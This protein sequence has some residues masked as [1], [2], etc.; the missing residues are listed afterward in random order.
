MK[1]LNEQIKE[2]KTQLINCKDP[3]QSEK[4]VNE[5]LGLHKRSLHT[6]T[7]LEV[8]C[9]EVQETVDFGACKISRTIRGFLFEAKGGMYTFVEHRMAS[10]CAMLNTIFAL[11]KEENKTKK[12]SKIYDTFV[13]AVEYVMQAPIFASLNEESLFSVATSVLHNFNEYS[14]RY[15]T[16]AQAPEHTEED[17]KEGQSRSMPLTYLHRTASLSPC[18]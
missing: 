3:R 13:T 17:Y 9:S 6:P 5:L 15:Y 1:N 14:D 11:N 2:V 7:E 4:L 12:E 10:V 16:D 18:S 8:P